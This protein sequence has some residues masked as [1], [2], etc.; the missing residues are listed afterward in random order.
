MANLTEAL[1]LLENEKQ[2]LHPVQ[3]CRCFRKFWKF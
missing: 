1:E 2:I 3:E